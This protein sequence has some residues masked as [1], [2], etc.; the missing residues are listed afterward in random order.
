MTTSEKKIRKT[1][2]N[3]MICGPNNPCSW[4]MKFT[5]NKSGETHAKFR[6]NNTFQG[7]EG[8]LHGGIITTLLDAVM[9]HCLFN[10]GIEALTGDLRVRFLHPIPCNKTIELQAQII[11]VKK[12]LYVLRAKAVCKEKIMVYSEAKFV[13]VK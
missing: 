2:S 5:H 7:Y 12:P 6:G 11:T 10:H 1:H 9:T 13:Q 3:C 8:I 4:Q